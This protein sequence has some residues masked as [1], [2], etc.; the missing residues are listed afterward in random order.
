MGPRRAVPFLAITFLCCWTIGGVILYLH[1]RTGVLDR[2]PG[3]F[4]ALAL[5]F[6]ITPSVVAILL[7]KLRRHESLADYGF[8]FRINPWWIPAWVLPYVIAVLTVAVCVL[9][10]WGQFDPRFTDFLAELEEKVPPEQF[11]QAKRQIQSLPLAVQY[12]MM[13][14][15]TLVAGTTLNAV[16]AFGEE[17]G[18]RGLLYKDLRPMGFWRANLLIG[19]IWGVWHAPIILTGYN[20]PQHPVIG[21]IVMIGGAMALAILIGYVRER[22]GSVIAA[23]IFHGVF[24]AAAT[25]SIIALANSK[26]LYSSPLGLGG[27]VAMSVIVAVGVLALRP[28]G[29]PS[30]QTAP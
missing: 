15:Q 1:Y 26:H 11:E 22:S 2:N 9:F 13:I 21:S 5:L 17:M 20:F 23:S 30:V 3:L 25:Y 27:I 10:G 16:A 29:R 8:T 19:F 7:I 28:F 12:L 24:N 18:W 4:G 6:M 14:G